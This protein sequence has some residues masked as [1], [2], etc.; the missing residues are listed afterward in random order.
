MVEASES[1]NLLQV[2]FPVLIILGASLS[3][4]FVDR[5]I[6]AWFQRLAEK[7][8]WR[9]D[10]IIIHT[11][12]SQVVLWFLL[13]GIY[14]ATWGAPVGSWIA[15][16]IRL[17]VLVVV[18]ISLVMASVHLGTELVQSHDDDGNNRATA[19]KI[20]INLIRITAFGIGLTI[21]LQ[22][23]GISV[24]PALA[25]LGIGGLALSLALQDTLTNVISG[26]MI[27]LSNQI[28]AGNY[29]RL[30]TGEEGYVTEINWR[31]TLIR[32]LANNMII[33]PNV[34]L[35][36]QI[37]RNYY[38]PVKELSILIDVGVSYNSDLEHVERVTIEVGKEVMQEVVGG[39]K[40]FTPL[41]RYNAFQDF[42][43]NFTVVLRGNEF[44]DQYVI[45][46]EFVK[47]LHKRYH[48]EGI[49]IALPMR[50]IFMHDGV[51]AHSP[52]HQGNR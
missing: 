40:D 6:L 30:S 15:P 2:L 20:I 41:V 45:K 37:L 9:T 14:A 23:F 42:R 19:F 12:R 22:M 32:E 35:T 39:V 50:S 33:I 38:E 29:I 16:L 3:G 13:L 51:E 10:D 46:H 49:E 7:T 26:V 4:L 44:V 48:Q 24:T 5:V 11:I 25:A 43:I 31:N 36:S 27:V 8:S 18:V 21:I 28:R 34:M 47:R 1:L 17:A 52:Q